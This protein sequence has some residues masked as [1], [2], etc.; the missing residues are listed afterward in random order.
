MGGGVSA[1]AID[2]LA[3]LGA[4]EDDLRLARELAS[5]M[6]SAH[7]EDDGFE[8]H[9]DCWDDV[10]FFL[11]VQTQWVWVSGIGFT[12]RAGF[13]YEALES[14]MR[15]QRVPRSRWPALF[16]AMQVM[17]AAVLEATLSR[18]LDEQGDAIR[19]T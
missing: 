1:E 17:E 6:D 15:M 5:E 14:A 11:S 16:E 19:R 10:M 18:A 3:A 4:S 7:A 9:E 12:Q 13:R 2:G 8:V